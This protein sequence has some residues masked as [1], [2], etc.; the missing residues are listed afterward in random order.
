MADKFLKWCLTKNGRNAAS[1]AAFGAIGT[2]TFAHVAPHTFLIDYYVDFLHH[3]RNG[4]AVRLTDETKQKFEKVL[5]LLEVDPSKRHLYNPFNIVGF[6]VGAIGSLYTK[7]GIRVGIPGN[8]A[9]KRE[10][11]IDTSRIIIVGE[12]LAS[13]ETESGKKLRKSLIISENAQNFAIARE[14]KMKETPKLIID[15]VIGT[16]SSFATYAISRAINMKYNLYA[17]P[18]LV[19][20]V[21]YSLVT[22]FTLGNYFL[23]KDGSQVYYE[24]AIDKELKNKS[25]EFAEGGKEY[26]TKLLLRNICLRNLLGK[27]GESLFSPL[28]NENY[29]IRMR[30]M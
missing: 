12:K 9:F 2:V 15:T 6:N 13:W 19:R 24:E 1:I 30:T 27:E 16:T 23:V 21:M 4:V 7:W 22:C 25:Q 8:F 26:Y 10:T 28:G 20:M 5:D 14:I 3:Y 18:L 29:F 17:K 11:E